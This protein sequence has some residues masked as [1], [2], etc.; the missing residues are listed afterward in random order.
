MVTKE[1]KLPKWL[2]RHLT[3]DDLSY[4]AVA[5]RQV[6]LKTSAEIVPMV[7]KRSMVSGHVLPMTI[8]IL[9]SLYL[10]FDVGGQLD[11]WRGTAFYWDVIDLVLLVY[12]ALG[13]SRLVWVERLLTRD[14]DEEAQVYRRAELEFFEAGLDKTRDSTGILLFVSLDERRAIVLADKTISAKVD[15]QTWQAVVDLMTSGVKR[16]KLSDGLAQAIARCGDLV[17][18]HIPRTTDDRNELH[19]ALVIKE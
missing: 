4:V 18:P 17:S 12:G 3:R 1:T 16:G 2:S 7:V 13:L 9:L 8:L 6:E 15:R 10:A 5:V 11:W 19:D 14:R